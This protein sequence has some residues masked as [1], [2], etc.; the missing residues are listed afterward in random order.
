M[1]GSPLK[2][3]SDPILAVNYPQYRELLDRVFVA[4]TCESWP[5]GDSARFSD[6]RYTP[7]EFIPPFA[8]EMRWDGGGPR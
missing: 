6:W 4:I 5:L 2:V 7:Q 1:N 3:R 8:F